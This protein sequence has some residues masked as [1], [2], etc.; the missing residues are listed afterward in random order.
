MKRR[1]MKIIVPLL[2]VLVLASGALGRAEEKTQAPDTFPA[3]PPAGI[4][5]NTLQDGLGR[6]VKV[7]VWGEGEALFWYMEPVPGSLADFCLYP[8]D[9]IVT[10]DGQLF[11]HVEFL[12]KNGQPFAGPIKEPLLMRFS[13]CGW[14]QSGKRCVDYNGSFE[15]F[16]PPTINITIQ[17]GVAV[18]TNVM[19]VK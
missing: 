9:I 12:D 15:V 11:Q 8:G 17:K 10:Q 3:A 5:G 13:A 19:G 14:E 2:L 6:A 16:V 18:K 7:L 4:L 1:A